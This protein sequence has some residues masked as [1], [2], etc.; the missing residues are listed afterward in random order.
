MLVGDEVGEELPPLLGLAGVDELC[1]RVAGLDRAG[2]GV[3]A[4]A[5]RNTLMATSPKIMA[6]IVPTWK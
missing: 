4:V 3:D 6:R 5:E 1:R 2:V